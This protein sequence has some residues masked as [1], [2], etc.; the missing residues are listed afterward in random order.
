[1]GDVDP[2]ISA[3]RWPMI[4]RV[5]ARPKDGRIIAGVAAGLDDRFAISRTLMRVLFVAALLLPG[6][7]VLIYSILWVIIPS[8]E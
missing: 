4:L 8:Q 1:M 6:P 7:Q 5:L 2:A 3:P